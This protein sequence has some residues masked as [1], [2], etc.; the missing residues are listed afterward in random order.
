MSPRARVFATTA[1]AAVLV[2]GATLGITLY[3][4]RD[5]TTTA[6]GSVTKPRTGIPPLLFSFGVRRDREARELARAARLLDAGDRTGAAEIFA[7]YDSLQ[8]RIGGAFATWPDGS[9]DA[10]KEIAG[11]HPESAVAQ[12]HLGLAL[13]WSGRNADAARVLDNVDDR[14]PDSPSS[15]DAENLLYPR[16]FV[17]L[18]YMVA[19]VQLPQAPTLAAQLDKAKSSPLAYGVMLW[20]L[21]RR[22][23]ARRQ[24]DL[25][26]AHAPNDP[27]VLTLDAVSHYS[28]QDPA[29]AFGRLG[30]LTGRFPRAAVVRLHL[31]LLLLWQKDVV[32]A[33]RQLRLAIASEPRS[34]YANQAKT[35][36]S[37]LAKSG[38]K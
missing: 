19:P 6:P 8:A 20:R 34:I 3:Q 33:R 27:V 28:K 23:S 24:L 1:A 35:L 17:G 13:L 36:I 18:P 32:K 5:E 7:R 21:D 15:V 37:A 14:F 29:A 30:P 11:Q 12:L 26:A 25:A 22:V 10:V 16:Y 2:V 9:L 38:T 4:T 31:G